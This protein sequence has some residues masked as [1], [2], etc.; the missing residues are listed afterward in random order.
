MAR[1]SLQLD[2]AL[3][4]PRRWGG[5]RPRAGRKPGPNRGLPH[6][7]RQD[8][9]TPLPA[10]VTM[11]VGPGVPSLRTVAIVRAVERSFADACARPGFRLVALLPPGQSRPPHR[12]GARSTFSRLRDEGDR[13]PNRPRRESRR[14]AS[15]KG[16][17]GSVPSAPSGNAARG[18]PRASLRAVER[19]PPSSSRSCRGEGRR[20]LRPGIVGTLVRR[21]E[22]QSTRRDQITGTLPRSTG[23]NVAPPDRLA[24]SWL[25]RPRR[26]SWLNRRRPGEF[27]DNLARCAEYSPLSQRIP[28]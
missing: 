24:S 18:P 5:R 7:S 22:R 8:F 28:S 13:G 26:C 21:M 27:V 11:R 17:H 14:A 3:R 6:T 4:E 20:A 2:F 25:A 10:H 16:L 15:R 12:R 9:S 19:A 1:R 23:K